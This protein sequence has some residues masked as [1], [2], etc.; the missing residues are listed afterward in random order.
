M[1]LAQGLPDLKPE[2]YQYFGKL[3]KEGEE[4]ELSAEEA[5]ERRIMKLLLKVMH[6]SEAFRMET[7]LF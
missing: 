1:Q 4:A 3:L 5:K 2:D 6:T 7:L